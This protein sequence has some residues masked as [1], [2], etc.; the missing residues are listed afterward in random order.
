MFG[1]GDPLL[2]ALFAKIEQAPVAASPAAKEDN[3]LPPTSKQPQPCEQQDGADE[4]TERRNDAVD[5]QHA[6]AVLL[7]AKRPGHGEASVEKNDLVEDEEDECKFSSTTVGTTSS[8]SSSSETERQDEDPKVE[9]QSTRQEPPAANKPT[10][11]QLPVVE[12]DEPPPRPRPCPEIVS[13][14]TS[15]TVYEPLRNN[16]MSVRTTS[17]SASTTTSAK[18]DPSSLDIPPIKLKLQDLIEFLEQKPAAPPK[19]TVLSP[20]SSSCQKSASS[21]RPASSSLSESERLVFVA[22]L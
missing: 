15:R 8:S 4:G 13:E 10:A 12:E 19:T 7:G 16:R 20:G 1:G 22:R 2:A 3:D 18:I 9:E 5:L 11:L 17:T 21:P 6:E 14:S